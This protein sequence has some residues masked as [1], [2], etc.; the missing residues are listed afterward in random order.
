MNED[1]LGESEYKTIMRINKHLEIEL[2]KPLF[3]M[4]SVSG[5]SQ[6]KVKV[7]TNLQINHLYWPFHYTKID[8]LYSDEL[9]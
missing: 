1:L 2:E 7:S 4:V 8:T 9:G 3:A 5:H 6:S